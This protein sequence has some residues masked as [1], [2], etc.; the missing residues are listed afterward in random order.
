LYHNGENRGMRRSRHT[1]SPAGNHPPL[2]HA[3]MQRQRASPDFIR[4]F[5]LPSLDQHLRNMHSDVSMMSNNQTMDTSSTVSTTPDR[6][7]ETLPPHRRVLRR[8]PRRI[9]STTFSDGDQSEDSDVTASD[10]GRRAWEE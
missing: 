7:E 4:S 6:F 9:L 2:S 5:N 8:Q 3:N 1:I 10:L